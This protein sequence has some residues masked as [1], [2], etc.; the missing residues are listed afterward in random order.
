[1][2]DNEIRVK[3]RKEGRERFISNLG[4]FAEQMY[5]DDVNVGVGIFRNVD[6]DI[7]SK[8]PREL[9]TWFGRLKYEFFEIKEDLNLLDPEWTHQERLEKFYDY[10]K[11]M[12]EELDIENILE[13]I[14]D[15]Y[16]GS[17]SGTLA[18]KQRAELLL[19]MF[20]VNDYLR[21]ELQYRAEMGDELR[22]LLLEQEVLF[23]NEDD[24][25]KD[26]E[27]GVVKEEK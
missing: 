22:Q 9:F 4:Y 25:Q 5:C 6:G 23:R 26:I 15:W 12:E 27:L 24:W 3:E 20:R 14:D 19:K 10:C 1:M 11:R 18:Y 7:I 17:V 13:E 2:N 21:N 16:F 8:T